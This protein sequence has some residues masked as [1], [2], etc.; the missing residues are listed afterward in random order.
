MNYYLQWELMT[1]NYRK[2][3]GWILLNTLESEKPD[4]KLIYY[5]ILLIKVKKL[6]KTNLCFYV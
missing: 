5:I 4:V 2:K 1:Y 3:P 6:G